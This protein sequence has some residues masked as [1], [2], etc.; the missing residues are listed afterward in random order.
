VIQISSP[1][2]GPG[3]PQETGYRPESL[4]QGVNAEGLTGDFSVFKGAKNKNKLGVFAKLLQGLS[5]KLTKGNAASDSAKTG[6]AGPDGPGKIA[7]KTASLVKN[8]KKPPFGMDVPDGE[9]LEEGLLNVLMGE[10]GLNPVQTGAEIPHL[11]ERLPEINQKKG[12]LDL[13]S[14]LNLNLSTNLSNME[15][16]EK[17][18][19]VPDFPESKTLANEQAQS[20]SKAKSGRVSGILSTLRETEAE[21]AGNQTQQAKSA[22]MQEPMPNGAERENLPTSETRGRKSKDRLNIEVRD[23]RTGEG[24]RGVASTENN[25]SLKEAIESNLRPLSKAEIEIP[26]ELDLRKGSV[27]GKAGDSSPAKTFEDALAAQLRGNLSTDIVRDASVIVRNGG[28]G[29]I[30]LSLRPASLGDVKIRLE[31]AE[32]KISGHII[33]ESG[34]ALRAFERELPVLEKAFRD[35]GF[36]ETNLQMFLASDNSRGGGAFGGREEKQ[37]RDFLIQPLAAARYDSESDQSVIL[38]D[39]MDALDG[40]QILSASPGRIPVNL[41]V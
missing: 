40:G 8:A 21:S 29:T 15:G 10:I 30:R 35:S 2:Q 13:N 4:S 9:G 33:V 17:T 5:V 1:T 37:E 28:E 12:L 27:D 19:S 6:E 24:Q 38:M 20:G 11:S 36:S 18:D 34:E 23:L 7:K 26:V 39:R 3:S 31:L 25:V 41:F 14:N 22:L 16:Q 32:N